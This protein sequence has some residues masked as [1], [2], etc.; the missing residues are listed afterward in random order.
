ML[1]FGETTATFGFH[2]LKVLELFHTI[3]ALGYTSVENELLNMDIFQISLDLFF[4]YQWN[5][6]LHHIVERMFL[7]VLQES[8]DEFISAVLKKINLIQSIC[9]AD[10]RNKEIEVKPGGIRRS[11]MG[12]LLS[13]ATSIKQLAKDH[14]DVQQALEDPLWEEFNKTTLAEREKVASKPLGGMAPE[15]PQS[16][17]IAGDDSGFGAAFG[18]PSTEETDKSDSED[19]E[20]SEELE[21]DLDDDVD[22]DSESDADDYDI[23]QAE[24][25]LSKQEIESPE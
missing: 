13:I 8:T 19:S 23:D 24:V 10:K 1:A 2:R 20:S 12:H 11:Y 3:L 16:G 6:F 9:Q 18:M 22:M 14:P 7:Y 21:L 17:M 5:N 25:L 15:R 4:E